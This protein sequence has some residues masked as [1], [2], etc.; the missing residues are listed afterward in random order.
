MKRKAVE[1][2]LV[3]SHNYN[4]NHEKSDK[5]Y[6]LFVL[7]TFEDLYTGN[8]YSNQTVT[9]E[10]DV[11]AHDIRKL[12]EMMFKANPNF[13]EVLFS[14]EYVYKDRDFKKI[15]DLRD[16]IV[17]A[18]LPKFFSGSKGISY[19]KVDLIKKGK[20]NEE[21][22]RGAKE[23][24]HAYRIAKLLEDFALSGFKDYGKH[25]VQTPEEREHM[26]KFYSMGLD[27]S[28]QVV[29]NYV[30][31]VDRKYGEFYKE[32]KVDTECMEEVKEIVY[33]MVKN[34]ITNQKDNTQRTKCIIDYG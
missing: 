2:I 6:K 33:T 32:N 30:E 4:L 1:K 17:T 18:N 3:G 26:F 9:E 13:L 22:E 19:K 20:Y 12:P 25:L 21:Y 5:D 27:D 34:H 24:L 8:R 31:E 29:E 10:S 11:E 28:V 16:R 23:A 15:L 7:P 14:K